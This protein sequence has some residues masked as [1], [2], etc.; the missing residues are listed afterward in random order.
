MAKFRQ[1]MLLGLDQSIL[2][3]YFT[4]DEKRQSDVFLVD[5]SEVGNTGVSYLSL[6][7]SVGSSPL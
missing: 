6:I 4:R 2:N 7:Q 3:I 5:R 1:N